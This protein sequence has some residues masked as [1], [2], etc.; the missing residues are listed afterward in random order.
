VADRADWPPDLEA[1][2]RAL[3]REIDVP[4]A[5]D[6]TVA[7]RR[8]LTQPDVRRRFWP[9][10]RGWRFRI[11]WRVAVP[12][13]LALLA[14][15]AV[16]PPGQAVI[17]HVFRFAGIELR[18]EPGPLPTPTGTPSLPNEQRLPLAQARALVAFPILVPAALGAPD[19][20]VVSD[21]G[22]VASLVYRHTPYGEVR[23]DEFDGHLS[24]LFFKKFVQAGE[25]S[26]VRVAGRPGIW[27][28]GPHEIVYVRPDGVEDV[29][30]ARLT[31]GNTLIWDTGRVAL[32]LEGAL[33]KAQAIAVATSVRPGP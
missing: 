18:Q 23:V 21:G 15:L 9:D 1:E 33:D 25:V 6:L 27:A 30:S 5:P 31:T 8:R 10:V 29:A 20:V 16:T 4:P 12:I 2:L 14:V 24:P 19:E 32:R 17:V 26:G 7:V 11:R 13:V 3:G 28:E 22:R